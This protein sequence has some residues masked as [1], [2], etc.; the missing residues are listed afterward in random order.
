MMEQNVFL[1]DGV[2]YNVWVKKLTRKFAV[3]DT[4]KTGRTQSGGMYRDVIG[5]YYN[6]TMV[7]EGKVGA[8]GELDAFWEAVSRPKKSHLCVFPYN[9][10]TLTQQM[11]VTGGEQDLV[12]RTEKGTQWGELTLNFVAMVPK[13]VP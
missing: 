6:Y 5:T 12:C 9:Q 3:L 10:I 8:A 13:V 7:V 4:G 1:M 11:Y 2:A